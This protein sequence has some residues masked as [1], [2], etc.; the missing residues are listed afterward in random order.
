MANKEA[1]G[2]KYRKVNDYDIKKLSLKSENGDD[3]NLKMMKWQL[4]F[5]EDIYANNVSGVI[6]LGDGVNLLSNLPINGR[7]KITFSFITP[8]VSTIKMV[9]IEVYSVNRFK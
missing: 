3:V 7:E 4:H 1:H 5:Y 2:G 9:V 6:I 8:D